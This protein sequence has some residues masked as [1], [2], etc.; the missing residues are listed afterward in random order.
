MKENGPYGSRGLNTAHG[1][2]SFKSTPVLSAGKNSRELFSSFCYTIACVCHMY[3]QSSWLRHSPRSRPSS[4]TNCPTL[5]KF[6]PVVLIISSWQLISVPRTIHFCGPFSSNCAAA[7]QQ[8]WAEA[9]RSLAPSEFTGCHQLPSRHISLPSRRIPYWVGRARG[10]CLSIQGIQL[11]IPCPWKF[12]CSV[13][14]CITSRPNLVLECACT[15][16][17]VLSEQPH[18]RSKG[19]T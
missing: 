5:A 6:R 13:L 17:N 1:H 4:Q 8:R 15:R 16:P 11:Y 2:F 14:C 10:R 7:H 9:R 3:L 18:T 12:M 19:R